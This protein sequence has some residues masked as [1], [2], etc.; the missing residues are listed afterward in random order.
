MLDEIKADC[1]N[2]PIYLGVAKVE[3]KTT[4]TATKALQDQAPAAPTLVGRVKNIFDFFNRHKIV[5]FLATASCVSLF[6]VSF[7]LGP[8]MLLLQ[9]AV[10]LTTLLYLYGYEKCSAV[11]VPVD[12]FCR[13]LAT[14]LTA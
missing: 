7:L 9:P 3:D 2:L 5:L 13:A 4:P 11:K 14:A 12:L 8:L 6:V 1:K 10:I